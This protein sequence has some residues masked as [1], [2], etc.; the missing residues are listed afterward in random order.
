MESSD[1]NEL[2]DEDDVDHEKRQAAFTA[3]KKLSP[4]DLEMI[5]MRF[6]EKKSFAE[7]SEIRGITPIFLLLLIPCSIARIIQMCRDG[8][9]LLQACSS[10][11]I[12]DSVQQSG[13][14]LFFG[15]IK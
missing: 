6:F 9:A 11:E 5:E 3:I 4:A 10:S 13:Q 8:L 1:M 12:H 14:D 2:L 15:F 7:I